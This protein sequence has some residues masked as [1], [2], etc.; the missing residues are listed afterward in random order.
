MPTVL[1]FVTDKYGE[2]VVLGEGGHAVVYLGC[3][4]GLMV[5]VKVGV[6]PAGSA[7]AGSKAELPSCW[8]WSYQP[9]LV[10]GVHAL[11]LPPLLGG[12]GQDL[13]KV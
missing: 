2:F 11:Q 3:L 5:A 12:W 10:S 6:H 7:A 8:R 1:Q 4:P 13:M 9:I